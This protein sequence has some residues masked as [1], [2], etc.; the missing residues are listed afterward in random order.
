MVKLGSELAEARKRQG[1]T[2]E[3]LA[4]GLPVSRETIAKYEINQ[5][6]FQKD[7][8]QQIS[9]SVDDPE[10]YFATWYEA[11]GYVS[12]PYF[13]G[14][15][16]DRHPASMKYMVHQETNQALNQMERVCWA[17]PISIQNEAE[18]EE[19]KRVIHEILDAAASMINLVAVLCK[20]YDFSMKSIYKI[21]W[22]SI[23]TRRWKA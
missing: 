14:D 10:Y 6:K 17:K 15:Y 1:L 7:L 4:M 13:N 16:I 11:T 2:Q 19:A 18:R 3:Q 21:W 22:S 5:R 20:E 8:Y 9:H 23:K 12:I